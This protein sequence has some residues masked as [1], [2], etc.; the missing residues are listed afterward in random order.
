ML[1]KWF[2][3]AEEPP[4]HFDPV[5]PDEPFIAIGDVHGRFDILQRFPENNVGGQIIFL[6]DMI[7]RGEQSADVLNVLFAVP[8]IICLMGNHEEMMLDFIA[9]PQAQGGR[10]LRYGGLQT[11]ASFGVWGISETSTG[12]ELER[13]RDA[14]VEAMGQ[15]LIDWIS[16]LPKCWTSGNVAFVHAGA[17]PTVPIDA[18][19]NRALLWGHNDFGKVPRKDGMWI[20]HGHTITEQP[21]MKPGIISIDTGAYAT[22]NL[23]AATIMDGGVEF[24]YV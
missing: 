16:G 17:D 3:R 11:L 7:D 8:G 15:D 21:M 2:K 14:L 12:G 24:E 19:K 9:Q 13:A 5:C 23:T 6:G 10:W 1:G 22:D 18:Q 4:A 20:V